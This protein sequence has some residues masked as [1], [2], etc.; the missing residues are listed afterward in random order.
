MTY[1]K[2]DR[3]AY[4]TTGEVARSLG[5]TLRTVQNWVDAGHLPCSLTVGRHRRI[6]RSHANLLWERMQ[7]RK[8]LPNA[9]EY[10][11]ATLRWAL[12]PAPV[13]APQVQKLKDFRA[14][15]TNAA[16]LLQMHNAER[17]RAGA[18]VM[19]AD[20]RGHLASHR[21]VT[22]HDAWCRGVLFALTFLTEEQA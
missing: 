12:H 14:T 18:P 2:I 13:T 17:E 6:H 5:V 3:S 11:V 4:G 9:A 16:W 21:D 7:N 15:S 22:I 10:E 19:L 1:P 8:P 20:L